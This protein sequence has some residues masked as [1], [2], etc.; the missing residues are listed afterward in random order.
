MDTKLCPGSENLASK[1]EA[2]VGVEN[3]KGRLKGDLERGEQ[4]CQWMGCARRTRNRSLTT[5]RQ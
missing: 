5:Y 4:R 1:D 2:R 3:K